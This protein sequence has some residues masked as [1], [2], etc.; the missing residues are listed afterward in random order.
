MNARVFAFCALCSIHVAGPHTLPP[1]KDRCTGLL[2]GVPTRSPPQAST[3]SREYAPP[4]LIP[5]PFSFHSNP[6]SRTYTQPF[7]S[8]MNELVEVFVHNN[9]I[10]LSLQINDTVVSNI[11][12]PPLVQ[13]LPH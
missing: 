7:K 6:S 3:P 9:M 4:S 10:C 13:K 12:I 2:D 11:E 5:L 1:V 8:S